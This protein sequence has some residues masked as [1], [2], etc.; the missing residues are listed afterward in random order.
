MTGTTLIFGAT[1]GIGSALA[2]RLA[3][4]GRRLH[5][6]ARSEDKVRALAD[7]LGAGATTA[8]VM[9][10]AQVEA[11]VDAAAP[12]GDLA[13][14][15]YCVGSITLKPLKKTT[16]QDFETAFRLNVVGAATALRRAA[17]TLSRN[18]GAAVLFSTVAA[19]YGFPSHSVVASAKAGVEGLIRATAAELAPAARVNGI[20]PSLTRTPL[21]EPIVANETMAKS[22]AKAHPMQRLGEPDDIAAMAAFLLDSHQ[23]GWV[24]GQV[25]GVDGGRGPLHVR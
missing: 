3:R 8:D 2:R 9:D 20:A 11:A 1:G 6:V 19:G 16:T 24:T 15:A 5:L 12:D 4:E 21:A 17:P 25:F 22:V 18:Q 23:S 7:E 14:L 10:P 13:G